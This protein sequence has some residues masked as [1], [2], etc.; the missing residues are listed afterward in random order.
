[1]TPGNWV[2]WLHI[3][4]YCNQWKNSTE[5][6]A[7]KIVW[8]KD[9]TNILSRSLFFH[10]FRDICLQKIDLFIKATCLQFRI[11][12]TKYFR[13]IAWN[14]IFLERKTPFSLLLNVSSNGN[15]TF[16][17]VITLSTRKSRLSCF[18]DWFL[19]LL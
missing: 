14:C 1:M 13:H 10:K 11:D 17:Q 15:S 16:W 7:T 12:P 18:C 6:L 5:L 19:D 8:A 2:L 4:I 3:H 9:S